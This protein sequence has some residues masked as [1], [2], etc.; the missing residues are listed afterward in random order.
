LFLLKKSSHLS[1]VSSFVEEV[2]A[3]PE[4]SEHCQRQKHVH[5]LPELALTY[6]RRLV[7]K[8]QGNFS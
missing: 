1:G 7:E 4:Q 8:A 5:P 2:E 3:K 6:N